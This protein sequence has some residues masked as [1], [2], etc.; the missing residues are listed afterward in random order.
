VCENE[1]LVWTPE[2]QVS[3]PLVASLVVEC[4]SEAAAQTHVTVSPDEIV[5]AEGAK[6]IPGPTLIV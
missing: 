2:S 4:G 5:T 1:P 6:A 3:G